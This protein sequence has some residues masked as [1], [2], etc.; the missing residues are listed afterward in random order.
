MARLIISCSLDPHSRSRLMARSARM[1]LEDSGESVDWLD[2][3]E[4]A[5]PMCDGN[6]VYDQVGVQQIGKRVRD[7]DGI[8]LAAPV[9]NFDVNAAAKNLVELTGKA[10]QDQVVGFLLAA[11]GQSSYM[12][13]MSF[14]NSLMLDFRCLIL[15]KFVY[16]TGQAFEGDQLADAM[17]SARITELA[18]SL[19]RIADV[20]RRK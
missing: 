5:L 6:S 19:V 15:P 2:L 13:V 1:V 4:T 11:G 17:V 18:E 20:V 8:I 7:A 3:Q 10:W 14:A 9:Y 16:A 12:S